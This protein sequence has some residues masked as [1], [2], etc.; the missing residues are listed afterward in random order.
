MN[1]SPTPQNGDRRAYVSLAVAGAAIVYLL[2]FG[3][4]NTDSVDISFVLFS[5]TTP[6]IVAMAISA[7]LGILIG[8]FGSYMLRR[9]RRK[10]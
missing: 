10:D 8:V 3:L 4:L 1:N 2:A 5:T 9:R 6:M 7:G